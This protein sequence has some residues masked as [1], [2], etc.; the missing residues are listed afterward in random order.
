M[1]IEEIYLNNLLAEID[2][3][4]ER[5]GKGLYRINDKIQDSAVDYARNYFAGIEGYDAVFHKCATCLGTYDV[6]ISFKG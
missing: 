4:K 2:R 1:R 3:I 6:M 5:G